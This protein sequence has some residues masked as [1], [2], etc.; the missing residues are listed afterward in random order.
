[1]GSEEN[2]H[3]LE[4]IIRRLH[5]ISFGFHTHSLTYLGAR[6]S[7]IKLSKMSGIARDMYNRYDLNGDGT[8]SAQEFATV[9][10]DCAQKSDTHISEEDVQAIVRMI[11]ENGD[12]KINFEEF[13]KYLME[14]GI[15]S[16]FL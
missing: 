12:G 11:D 15:P 8:I 14:L 13:K 1:M 9:V 5:N 7:T 4:W 16:E 10:R 6:F 3:T 2:V